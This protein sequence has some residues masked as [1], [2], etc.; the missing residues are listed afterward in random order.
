MLP[1]NDKWAPEGPQGQNPA[2]TDCVTPSY[3]PASYTLGAHHFPT[4][5]ADIIICKGLQTLCLDN[6]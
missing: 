1:S 6:E 3:L 4:S 5:R 2:R